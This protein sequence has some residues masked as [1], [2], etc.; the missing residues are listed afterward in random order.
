[1]SKAHNDLW[2]QSIRYI[3]G[4][5]NSPVRA[6][7]KV[8]G[9]PVF[10]DRARGCRFVDSD[11]NTYIDYVLSWG[12]LILGHAHPYVVAA[13]K[14]TSEKGTSFGAP[15]HNEALFA[16]TI[17]HAVPS[18]EKVRLVSSG[19]EAAMTAIRLARGV[20]GRDDII[21]FEG[22][23]HGHSD[24]LLVKAGSGAATLGV[25]DSLGVPA[26]FARHTITVPYNDTDAFVRT[27]E[28]LHENVAAVIVEPI[29]ANMGVI[30]PVEGF[31]AAL[32]ERCTRY[33]ILLIFDEVITGFRVGYGGAQEFYGLSPD[34]TVLGK[35]IG[36]GLPIG[37]VGGKAEIMDELAPD[38]GVYQAGT[39]SGNPV[40]VAAGM[41]TLKVLSE[42][43][44]YPELDRLTRN[45]A[46]GL[47]RIT[48]RL[49]IPAGFTQVG[50]MMSLFFSP[51][52]VRDFQSV[53]QTDAESY[54]RYFHGMLK[55]GVY[56]APS[57]YEATFLS[58]AHTDQDIERTLE[59]A[60][61]SLTEL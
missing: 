56:L 36:G 43:N 44:P 28:S 60:E 34:L 47:G 9:H 18:I 30:P 38:G 55:R 1:L 12:P 7:R 16:E 2:K 49:S 41:A 54:R 51:D 37:A 45:L 48:E 31:L 52:P 57:P 5:V 14:E 29:A 58:V 11:G 20:T 35:I 23:Y 21:K 17:A 33:G 4:G 50:S 22:C 15:T 6:F 61:K 25:P 3:P 32:R 59:A 27:V 39:L 46:E 53:L 19:T 42:E 40:A 8:G 13:I 10:F 24:S 26:D